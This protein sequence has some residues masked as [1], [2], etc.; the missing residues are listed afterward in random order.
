MS[1]PKCLNFSDYNRYPADENPTTDAQMQ[2]YM[3][4]QN[5]LVKQIANIVWQPQ[6][7]Y[8][9][10]QIIHSNSMPAGIFAVVTTA[11]QSGSN[12]PT[13]KTTGTVSDSGV[14]W[15]M[16]KIITDVTTTGTG[17]AVTDVSSN[18]G[19]IT[20]TKGATYLTTHQ[21]IS[22]KADKENVTAGTIGTN[23]E[24]EGLNIAVPYVNV[25]N[26]GVITGYGTRNHTI[27]QASTDTAGCVKVGENLS[28]DEDGVLSA[29]GGS[30]GDVV[31]LSAGRCTTSASTRAKVV[32]LAGYTLKQYDAILVYFTN[33]NTSSTPT[34]NVNGTGAKAIRPAD[35]K[36]TSATTQICYYDGT[37]WRVGGYADSTDYS[38]GS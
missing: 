18:N 1:I 9:A 38:G 10:G 7:S 19:A 34:L 4:N 31:K 13:W 35:W 6:T 21:D 16:I 37:Y 33:A 11:G 32:T 23:V 27:P 2:V 24:T 5:E 36:G 22:G 3:S 29:T 25:N 17:N 20:V 30:G 14:T 28:I 12:E 8:V 15:T 26:Q